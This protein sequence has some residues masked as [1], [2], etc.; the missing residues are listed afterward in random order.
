MAVDFS[1]IG[2]SPKRVDGLEKVTGSGK[3][4]VD[5][6][7]PGMLYGKIKRTPHAHAKID[8]IDT[9]KARQLPGVKAILTVENV[10]RIL[11]AGSPPPR[12]AAGWW[13]PG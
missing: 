5:M 7:L 10:P 12:A 9:S 2:T 11:H 13:D 4:A 3:Y 8:Q 1:V 6:I